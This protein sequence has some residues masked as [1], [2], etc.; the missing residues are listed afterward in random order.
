M[1]RRLLAAVAIAAMLA[2]AV[3]YSRVA[4]AE[5]PSGDLVELCETLYGDY[6]EPPTSEPLAACQWDMA[7]IGA[8]ADTFT[9][10][11]GEGVTVGVLDSGIDLDHPDLAPNIDVGLS[12]SFIFDDD[13][14]ALPVE[15]ANGDCSNKAAVQDYGDHGT[16]V[17]TTIAAPINGVGIAGVAPDATIVGIKVCSAVGY[18]FAKS[19]AAALRYSGDIGLDIVNLSLYADPYLYY[20]GNDAEQRAIYRDLVEAA[21]YA[22]QRGVLIISSAGNG[23][24]DLRHPGVDSTSPDWP[25]GEAVLRDVGN[26]CRVAPA[27]F[28]GTV[29]VMSTGPIGF[30]GYEQNIAGYSTVGG[31][32]A[33]P[34]GDY[35]AAS[36]TVQD[37]ILGGASSTSD[38]VNG[39]FVALDPLSAVFPGLTTSDAGGRYMYING[40][41]MASPHAAGVAALIAEL[42]PNW[43]PSAI[44]AALKRT[45]TPT[46]CPADWAPL[47]ANDE[48]EKCRGGGNGHT[49]FF[50]H[51]LVDAAAA[52]GG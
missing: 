20:C 43:G 8:N 47:N 48:R 50:G 16:H 18:C 22:Q 1:S 11:T 41:S 26:N 14:L 52:T 27:E 42:N 5:T 51:G 29:S 28:P 19:V 39:I 24:S 38:A 31:T 21:R 6:I 40:T 7:I 2:V 10:A 15:I 36:G 17:A 37:A 35:F 44:A 3:P 32:L 9:R 13:P 12:C 49:S 45:A 33:A 46:P 30:P 34:G 23:A 25:P 4:D